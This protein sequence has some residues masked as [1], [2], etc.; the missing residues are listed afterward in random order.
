MWS[1]VAGAPSGPRPDLLKTVFEHRGGRRGSSDGSSLKIT[2][3]SPPRTHGLFRVPYHDPEAH[4]SATSDQED[5]DET[6]FAAVAAFCTTQRQH[7]FFAKNCG[8]EEFPV[9]KTAPKPKTESG[10]SLPRTGGLVD[11]EDIDDSTQWGVRLISPANGRSSAR[12]VQY[13][14]WGPI[15][16]YRDFAQWFVFELYGIVSDGDERLTDEWFLQSPLLPIVVGR[17]LGRRVKVGEAVAWGAAHLDGGLLVCCL[18]HF[19]VHDPFLGYR[20]RP[21][22]VP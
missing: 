18:N 15:E 3:Q 6:S 9:L 21:C 5:A 1:Y 7:G 19:G 13:P 4:G 22:L 2:T 14:F 11:K 12:P 16:N 8:S 10:R 20:C 17:G